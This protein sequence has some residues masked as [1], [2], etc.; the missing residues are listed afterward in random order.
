MSPHGEPPASG[1][2]APGGPTSEREGLR[3]AVMVIRAW[4]E[5]PGP[6][7]LR[8]RVWDA[9]GVDPELPLRVRLAGS[10]GELEEVA[11]GWLRALRDEDADGEWP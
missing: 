3:D 1:G 4:R 9:A 2:P 8:A 10:A 6:D 5:A 11:L 7:G